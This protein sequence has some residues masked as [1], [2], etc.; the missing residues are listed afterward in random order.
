MYLHETGLSWFQAGVFTVV[1]V[2][3]FYSVTRVVC[4]GGVGFARAVYLPSTFAANQFGTNLLGPQGC[5]ALGFTF[6]WSGDIRTILMTQAAQGMRLTD[7]ISRRRPMLWCLLV[8]VVVGLLGSWATDVAVGYE[9]G[10]FNCYP[11]WPVW[12]AGVTHWRQ[13][14]GLIKTPRTPDPLTWA[15]MGVGASVMYGLIFLRQR[16]V[17]WPVHYV[18]LPVSTSWPIQQVW[19]SVFLAWLIKGL[20]LKFGTTG[21]YHR[22]RM[23]FLGMI[24]G[25]LASGGLWTI[26]GAAAQQEARFTMGVTLW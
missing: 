19:F 2:I 22:S 6:T 5:T 8:A 25:A 9:Y 13:V 14:A 11:S 24:F 26:V 3:V 20:I 15:F 10:L 18:G 7:P 1:A 16:F 17:W 12:T 23:F 4:E 21:L